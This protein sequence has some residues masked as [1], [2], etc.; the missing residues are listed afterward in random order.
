MEIER[1]TVDTAVEADRI[2][3]GRGPVAGVDTGSS[4]I[5]TDVS[6][7]PKTRE[8]RDTVA[9]HYVDVRRCTTGV[10]CLDL[11]V[12]VA[13]VGGQSV[14][15]DAIDFG[16]GRIDDGLD[17]AGFADG[18]LGIRSCVFAGPEKAAK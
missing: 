14:H 4:Q 15:G 12:E 17:D 13:P 16:A 9:V 2:Q 5:T 7:G 11:V 6:N 1:N 18:C 10:R 3:C 8:F